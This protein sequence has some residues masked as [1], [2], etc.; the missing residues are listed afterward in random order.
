M[1][2]TSLLSPYRKTPSHGPKFSQPPPDLIDGE[3]EYKVKQIKAHQNFGRSKHLQ[4]LMKWKGY[5]K[6]NNTWES[7]TDVH[8][9]E[10]IKEYHKHHPLQK[11][12]GQLLSLLPSSRF[13]FV[14]VCGLLMVML[15]YENAPGL[16]WGYHY[17]NFSVFT[18]VSDRFSR[19]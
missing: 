5:P 1:F 2:H 15:L 3:E 18:Y 6:S 4:Y 17:V 8:T 13:P 9:P 19:F 11:I 12:K 10:I 7:A 14:M 16:I